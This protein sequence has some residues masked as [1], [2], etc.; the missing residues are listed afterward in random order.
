MSKFIEGNLP[1]MIIIGAQKCGTTSLHYYLSLH[2]EIS[3]SKQK[4]L[5]FFLP[6]KNWHKG[7]EWYKSNFIGRAKIYGEASPG[8]SFYPVYKG[9]PERMYSIIPEAKLIYL[10]RDPVERIISH[11][12]HNYVDCNESKTFDEAVAASESNIYICLSKYFM[13]IE[14]YLKFYPKSNILIVTH[15]NLNKYR[16]QTL[17]KVFRFLCVDETIYSKKFYFKLHTSKYKRRKTSFGLRLSQCYALKLIKLLP[18]ELRG[19][20]EKLLCLPFSYKVK[21]PEL[22]NQL[23]KKIIEFIKEDVNHLR[24]FTGCRFESWSI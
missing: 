7:I 3:M 5:N 2:P 6:K 14:Q 4:E 15:E 16:R 12:F 24:K 21:W 23:R 8:Y 13:Q 9:V 17:Q 1:N 20:V 22:N 10:V 18:F 19:P 11:Y